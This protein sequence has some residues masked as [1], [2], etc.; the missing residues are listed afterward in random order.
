MSLTS[1]SAASF[2]ILSLATTLGACGQ[3]FPSANNGAGGSSSSGV[4]GSQAGGTGGA[5]G[6]TIVMKDP[7]NYPQN[8]AGGAFPYPQGHAFAHCALP[9]YNTDDVATIYNNWKS[10][11][12]QQGRVIRP[13]NSSDTASEGIAYGMLIGV[14]MNDRP[15]FDTLWSYAHSR[16]DGNGL[17][18][19]NYSSS[20]AALQQGAATDP[21]MTWP[22]R[23]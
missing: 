20:G 11:F 13:E 1:R 2:A 9:A 7:S 3:L 10:R 8:T 16:Y 19:W 15:M 21:T 14:Y 6:G 12:Y 22:G 5:P 4:G 17:M 18:T 23:C